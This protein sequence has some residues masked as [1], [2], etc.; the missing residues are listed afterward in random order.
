MNLRWLYVWIYV[1]IGLADNLIMLGYLNYMFDIIPA[2]QRP[3]YM[4]AFNA[5]GA[6]GVLGP[7]IAGWLLGLTSYAV[8]FAISLG[9]GL[10][11]LG[12]AIRLP[13]V[14]GIVEPVATD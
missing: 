12:L 11:T 14:R 13:R 10:L 5:I 4:G 3:I 8:L 9:F 7:S 6:I 1:C 2:G